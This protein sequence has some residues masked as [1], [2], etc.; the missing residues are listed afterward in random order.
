MKYLNYILIVLG[1]F[2][3]LYA[4]QGTEQNEYILIG[5]IAILVIGIYRISKTLPS[6]HDENEDTN[7]N[8]KE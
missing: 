7:V 3:A 4:K 8:D 5:G 6:K 1:A 2:A